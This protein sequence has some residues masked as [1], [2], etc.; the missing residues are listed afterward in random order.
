[1]D[2]RGDCETLDLS[3]LWI[4]F[5]LGGI[6]EAAK[7]YLMKVR[8]FFSGSSCF[9]LPLFNDQLDTC[10]TFLKGQREHIKKYGI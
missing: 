9:Y 2:K 3:L 8:C 1:M 6:S 7:V 4:P 5:L 10:E